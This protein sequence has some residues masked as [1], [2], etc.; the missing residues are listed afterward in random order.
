MSIDRCEPQE[1]GFDPPRLRRLSDVIQRDI[2]AERFDG[3]AV[4]VGRH[5]RI[6]Y[7]EHIGFAE[8]ASGRRIE[9]DQIFVTMSVGKQFTVA[10]VLN[11]I[12]RG[13]L[14]LTT[15]VADV[16]PEFG[17]RGKENVMVW[18]LLTHTGG[19]P[20]LLPPLPPDLVGNL[21]A[22]VAATCASLLE[23]DPGVRVTYSVIVAHAVLAE[24]VRRVD[25]GKRP[26]RQILAE[27]LFGPLG[28]TRTSLGVRPDLKPLVAPVVVRDRR[29]GL[30]DADLLEMMGT[31][32]GEDTEV[33][34][35]G[36]VSTA[37]DL[38]RFAEMLRRG[39]EL[40]GVRILSPAM[41]EA[42]QVVRTG[43]Q[44]NS[45]FEYTRATRGWMPF[46]ANLGLGFFVRGCGVHP[47]PFGTLASART[48]GGMGAGST[49]FWIDPVRDVTYAFM[50]TGLI[51]ES[52][53]IER[54][55]RLSDMVHAA[56]VG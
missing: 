2:D 16:I 14:A 26:F 45:L 47:T 18:H 19:L 55:Q 23:S 11:R 54:H 34:A 43:D 28:M 37:L 27:D 15:R 33:P 44:P 46:P 5:G 38:H 39:G 25:G 40:N 10:A 35:G 9:N 8:R 17:C 6:A 52:Y 56:I 20:A 50:S 31:M 3:C 42:V 30:L 4:V 12:E 7:Q 51:E 21:E 53:S 29:P 13:D 24:M 49:V 48:F 22:V 1:V 32:L 41:V 36:Y